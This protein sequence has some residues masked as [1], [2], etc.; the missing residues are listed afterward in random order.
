MTSTEDPSWP[1][2]S[3]SFAVPTGSALANDLL[4]FLASL[5]QRSEAEL[6]LRLFRETQSQTFALLVPTNGVLREHAGTLAEQLGYLQKLGLRPALVLGAIEPVDNDLVEHLRLN[7]KE[8]GVSGQRRELSSAGRAA[9]ASASDTSPA[10]PLYL[11]PRPSDAQLRQ[12][13]GMLHPRKLLFLRRAGGLGP[14]GS[15][16]VVL[17]DGHF[18]PSNENGIGVINLRSDGQ[19][20]L[21]LLPQ[22]ESRWLDRCSAL[23]ADEQGW[24][25]RETI[26]ITS[27]LS[28]LRE[29][30]TV[31]GA[32]TLVKRGAA[33]ASASDY[34]QLSAQTVRHL[35]EAAFGRRVKDDFFERSP[36]SLYFE[37][38]LRGLAVLEAGRGAAFLSKFAVLP[39]ARGEGLGQDL[40]WALCKRNSAIYFRARPDNPIVS[41]YASVCDGMQRT[42]KW[43]IYWKGIEA[44]LIPQLI[45]DAV[46]RPEDFEG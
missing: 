44:R 41:W 26:S 6:Y 7:L 14:H 25:A 15:G 46:S 20:L 24:G 18:L 34:A 30:F 35:L 27:P 2:G 13:V 43:N 38:S 12:L 21:R 11:A 33:I 17:P 45:Q 1:P 19:E 8:V 5:G 29:L 36:E 39:E 10:L 40:W 3:A 32:G 4:H 28:L 37:K 22:A 42:E 31:R 23:F 16:N 9:A